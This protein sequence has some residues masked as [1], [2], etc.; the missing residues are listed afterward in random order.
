MS[1]F[2]FGFLLGFAIYL[3]FAANGHV[4]IGAYVWIAVGIVADFLDQRPIPMER[5][6]SPPQNSKPKMFTA[7]QRRL[8]GGF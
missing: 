7:T 5:G 6:I 3:L 2:A 4:I 1:R 8:P